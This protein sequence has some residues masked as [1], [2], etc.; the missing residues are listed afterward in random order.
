MYSFRVNAFRKTSEDRR[1]LKTLVEV[2]G[3]APRYGDC[4]SHG[5]Q[6]GVQRHRAGV[7]SSVETLL[8]F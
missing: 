7:F 5:D 6:Y 1:M 4:V 3:D 2:T 8:D